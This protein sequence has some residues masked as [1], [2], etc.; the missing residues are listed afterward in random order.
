MLFAPQCVRGDAMTGATDLVG[1]ICRDACA[2]HGVS[3]DTLARVD[4]VEAP[5]WHARAAALETM[6]RGGMA[7]AMAARLVAMD[8]PQFAHLLRGPR[9]SWSTVV[10]AMRR[11]GDAITRDA[12]LYDR[13][14]KK[15]DAMQAMRAKR[16]ATNTEAARM[17]AAMKRAEKE[18]RLAAMTPEQRAKYEVRLAAGREYSRTH[19]ENKA[20]AGRKVTCD[21]AR[22]AS[23]NWR[24]RDDGDPQGLRW[25]VDGVDFSTGAVP[26]ERDRGRPCYRVIAPN[27]E[28][29]VIREA[30]C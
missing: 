9:R 16:A 24:M 8:R 10:A 27:V 23:F 25:R 28:A 26:D 7:W 19:A 22:A 17:R 12:E 6:M 2:R 3:P 20:T 11:L 15:R 1:M 4:C 13:R 14:A 29:V 30:S 21:P 18:A 5:H